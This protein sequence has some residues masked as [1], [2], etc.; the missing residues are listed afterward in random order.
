VILILGVLALIFFP[1]AFRS[2]HHGPYSRVSSNMKDI[3]KALTMFAIDNDNTFPSDKFA[4]N[5]YDSD[6]RGA[7]VLMQLIDADYFKLLNYT[8][9][10]FIRPPSQGPWI[11]FTGQKSTDSSNLPLLAAPE[12]EGKILLLH[13]GGDVT[14]ESPEDFHALLSASPATPIAILVPVR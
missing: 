14:R 6:H 1:L 12:I 7:Q 13:I 8:D 10:L 2:T 9:Q 11:Y 5:E 3:H 4:G